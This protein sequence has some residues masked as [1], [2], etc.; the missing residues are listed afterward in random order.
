MP[1]TL[2]HLTTTPR[3]WSWETSDNWH[4]NTGL[5]DP[6]WHGLGP[7]VSQDPVFAHFNHFLGPDFHPLATVVLGGPSGFTVF[8]PADGRLLPRLSSLWVV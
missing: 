8:L 3:V 1:W 4:L 5:P 2:R 6:G 7:R